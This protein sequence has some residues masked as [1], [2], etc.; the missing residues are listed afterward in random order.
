MAKQKTKK[1]EEKQNYISE[2]SNL[3]KVIGQLEGV[4]RMIEARRYCFDLLIQIKASRSTLKRIQSNIL[5][6]H[7]ED[8]VASSFANPDEAKQKIEEMKLLIDKMQS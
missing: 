1:F 4:K 5:C 8:C 3:N 7:L 6:K 2:I